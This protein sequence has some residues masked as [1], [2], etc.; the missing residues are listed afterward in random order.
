VSRS[1]LVLSLVVGSL[2]VASFGLVACGSF[3]SDDG[4]V[5]SPDA[6]VDA[7]SEATV[8]GEE[9]GAEA[10]AEAGPAPGCHGAFAGART[11]TIDPGFNG[12]LR[13]VR[14]TANG[15]FV[16]SWDTSPDDN[17]GTATI[18]SNSLTL[19]ATNPFAP[20]NAPTDESAP[21]APADLGFVL[22]TSNRAP[23]RFMSDAGPD[24]SLL[25][26]AAF[27]GS[28]SSAVNV[29]VANL[30]QETSINNPYLVG[31]RLYYDVAG[32]LRSGVVTDSD[33]LGGLAVAGIKVTAA[34]PVVTK[35]EGEIFFSTGAGIQLAVRTGAVGF[36]VMSNVI[37]STGDYPTWISDD[38][39]HLYVIRS[40]TTLN[41]YDRQP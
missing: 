16:V 4:P 6:A 31:S 23:G 29:A 28:F 8:P 5:A 40:G 38:A 35:D 33:V 19:V 24:L 9:A 26:R 11:I 2:A 20:L 41:V 13:S 18:V 37:G 36:D 25:F 34:H 39:C 7:A 21:T 3:A 12:S 22:F 15:V 14:G 32:T 17:M 30:P 27:N 1:F 10:G